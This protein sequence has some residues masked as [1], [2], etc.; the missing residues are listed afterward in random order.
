MTNTFNFEN[1]LIKFSLLKINIARTNYIFLV[2]QKDKKCILVYT[3][4]VL[5][6]MKIRIE[7]KYII[8]Y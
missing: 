1:L 4:L 5:N 6:S 2:L 3:I 8:S 7:E